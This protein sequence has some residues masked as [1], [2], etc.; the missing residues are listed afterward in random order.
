MVHQNLACLSSCDARVAM[1][2]KEMSAPMYFLSYL[3]GIFL[4][5]VLIINLHQLI[6]DTSCQ[7]RCAQTHA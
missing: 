6:M 7:V 4:L 1:L 2:I 5:L 3:L